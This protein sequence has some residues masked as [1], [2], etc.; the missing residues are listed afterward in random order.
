MFFN[1]FL[2]NKNCAKPKN[3]LIFISKLLKTVYLPPA[4]RQSNKS[5]GTVLF[6]NT[7]K[8]SYFV[9]SRK[10]RR[11]N[12]DKFVFARVHSKLSIVVISPLKILTIHYV[13][14]AVFKKLPKKLNFSKKIKNG[15]RLCPPFLSFDPDF[16]RLNCVVSRYSL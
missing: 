7:F 3:I 12:P 10:I 4:R 2:I 9:C 15:G 6:T 8:N 14:G 16:Y 11:R 13:I 1:E 5:E